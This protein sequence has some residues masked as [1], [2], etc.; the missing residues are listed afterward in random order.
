MT[1]EVTTPTQAWLLTTRYRRQ[2]LPPPPLPPLLSLAM[3]ATI[4]RF[5]SRHTVP[6][7][8]RSTTRTFSDLVVE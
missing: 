5:D 7:A 2:S 1:A 3:M 4:R 8:T 6:V